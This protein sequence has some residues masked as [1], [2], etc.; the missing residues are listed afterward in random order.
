MSAEHYQ[1]AIEDY[2]AAANGWAAVGL[3]LLLALV[4]DVARSK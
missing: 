1:N 2:R 4:V 3:I